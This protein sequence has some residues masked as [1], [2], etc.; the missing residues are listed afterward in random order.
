MTAKISLADAEDE[1]ARC[2][3]LPCVGMIVVTAVGLNNYNI[4]DPLCGGYTLL[5]FLFLWRLHV[6]IAL[7]RQMT[8]FVKQLLQHANPVWVKRIIC[9]LGSS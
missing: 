7:L 3:M 1:D 4:V 5:L 6:A 2:K 8:Q 9:H